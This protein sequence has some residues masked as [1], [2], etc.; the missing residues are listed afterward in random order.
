M[1]ERVVVY[2]TRTCPY[3]RAAK[4][5]LKSQGVRYEEVEVTDS[6]EAREKLAAMSGGRQTVPV[7]FAGK[8]CIGGYDELVELF[9][10]GGKL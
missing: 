8:R 4:E 7:I 10:G 2:T 1:P 6:P 5:L 9:H 3:C